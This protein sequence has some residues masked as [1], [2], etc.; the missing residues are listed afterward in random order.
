[1]NNN[2]MW[3]T[4]TTA[5][6]NKQQEKKREQRYEIHLYQFIVGSDGD[7]D[8]ETA[9][10]YYEDDLYK[11]LSIAAQYYRSTPNPLV[12]IFDNETAKYIAEWD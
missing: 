5:D 9:K 11:A 3:V 10:H 12:N 6:V 4:T 2:D 1:M 7:V 8:E